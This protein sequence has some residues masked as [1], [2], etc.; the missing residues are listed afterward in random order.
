MSHGFRVTNRV[1]EGEDG[2]AD[3]LSVARGYVE[4]QTYGYEARLFRCKGVGDLVV[5]PVWEHRVLSRR[6]TVKQCANWIWRGSRC[7]S[8]RA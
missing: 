4:P 1:T 3:T 6:C 5:Y 8:V 7:V 2:H